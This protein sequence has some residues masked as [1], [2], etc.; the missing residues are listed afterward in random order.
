VE[1]DLMPV[2][3]KRLIFTGSRLNRPERA[4]MD[5]LVTVL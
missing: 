1:I 2:M 5:V 3:L 4:Y